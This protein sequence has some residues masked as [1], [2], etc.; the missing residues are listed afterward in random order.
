MSTEHTW[1]V[2]L[3]FD[4]LSKGA[5]AL[6]GWLRRVGDTTVGVHVLESWTHPYLA[7]DTALSEIQDMVIYVS[8]ALGGESPL[9]RMS[10]LA[11]P[12][13]EE[14]LALACAAE[15]ASGLVIGRAASIGS[16]S[17]IRLG[18]VARHLLRQLPVAV[19]VVPPD[20]TF[21]GPGPILLATDL[22]TTSAAVGRWCV[23]PR[24][25]SRRAMSLLRRLEYN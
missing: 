12:R 22:S 5:L 1:V 4:G 8:K 10:V 16:E 19:I 2:G 23:R 11:A 6:A 17:F 13:A 18:A 20:Q 25:R 15:R 3:D 7:R 14:G 9:V 24:A 21:V